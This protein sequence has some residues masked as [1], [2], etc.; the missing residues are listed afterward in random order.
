MGRQFPPSQG[1]SAGYHFCKVRFVA[2]ASCWCVVEEVRE[3]K[4][5]GWRDERHLWMSDVSTAQPKHKPKFARMSVFLRHG[6]R[7]SANNNSS[8][9][10]MTRWEKWRLIQNRG[11]KW[12]YKLISGWFCNP[13]EGLDCDIWDA[14]YAPDSSND[15]KVFNAAKA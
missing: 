10:G 8:A 15:Q 6:F 4:T 13:C 11:Y 12:L 5:Y 7:G 1:K 9:S 3:C 2:A 14:F